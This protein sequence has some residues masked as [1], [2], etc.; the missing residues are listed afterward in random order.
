M[1]GIRRA[2]L[3]RTPLIGV[4]SL[5]ALA[6]LLADLASCKWN[7]FGM[8]QWGLLGLGVVV[9]IIGARAA[10]PTLAKL[11]LAL[12]ATIFVVVVAEVAMR[13]VFPIPGRGAGEWA[14]SPGSELLLVSAPDKFRAVHRYNT[15]GFRGP[16]VPITRTT[17]FRIVCIG[18][19]WT[20]G[21]GA[22]EVV[23]DRVLRLEVRVGDQVG[24]ALLADLEFRAPAG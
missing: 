5:L 3:P 8:V 15:L 2:C 16:E 12:A 7:G 21:V 6:A 18:D 10:L 19:S 20:E 17:P 22:E 13:F 23:A 9:L 11:N 1:T 14:G 24:P 4:G